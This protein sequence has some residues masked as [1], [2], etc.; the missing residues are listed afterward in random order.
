MADSLGP[1]LCRTTVQ[2]YSFA[3]FPQ[4]Q[5]LGAKNGLNGKF[6]KFSSHENLVLYMLMEWYIISSIADKLLDFKQKKSFNLAAL[7]V[8]ETNF[9]PIHLLVTEK[10][11]KKNT[12]VLLQLPCAKPIYARVHILWFRA[13]TCTCAKFCAWMHMKTLHALMSITLCIG[14]KT[15]AKTPKLDDLDLW[16]MT[17]TIKLVL[18]VIKV[19]ACTKFCDRTSF[20]SA[21]R[22]FT[23]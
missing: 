19:N 9:F 11:L 18:D 4:M 16:P 10:H 20:G 8:K 21:V 6:A 23:H 3:R 17:L 7:K 2:Q 14:Q 22:V 5:G 1:P 15:Q 12:K 13:C